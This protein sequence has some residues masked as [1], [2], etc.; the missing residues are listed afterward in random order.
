[1]GFASGFQAGLSAVK[2]AKEMRDERM[3]RDELAN[4]E[5]EYTQTQQPYEQ[6]EETAGLTGAPLQSAAPV[7]AGMQHQLTLR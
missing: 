6:A 7:Q 5:N 1:M 3:L 2:T 4:L